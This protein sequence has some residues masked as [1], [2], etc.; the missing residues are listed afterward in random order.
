[1]AHGYRIYD[2]HKAH[3]FTCT[4]HQWADVFTRREY[5]DILIESIRFCQ[6]NKGL[7]VYSWVIMTNHLHMI[8]GS[9]DGKLSVTIRDFKK[10]T[11]TQIVKAIEA[12]S[13]ES[14][15]KWLLWLF[16]K[17]Q[18]IWF[19]EEGFHPEEVR[20]REFFDVKSNYIH[21]NPVR[22][23]FV[24]KEDEYLYSSCGDFYGTRKGLLELAAF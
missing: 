21:M 23:G 10:F 9:E 7:Q 1:M 19:W 22:A 13:K 20:T 8:A 14:R 24:D 16:K 2:Q 4:V 5:I 17:D 12:N 15:K 18:G 6:I 11:A 3:F